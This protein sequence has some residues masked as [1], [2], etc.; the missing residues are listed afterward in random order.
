MHVLRS[1]IWSTTVPRFWAQAGIIGL[2]VLPYPGFGR[3]Q[4]L[5][6]CTPLFVEFHAYMV[7]LEEDE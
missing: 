1:L 5:L 2:Q 7:G 4:E 6:A 3:E